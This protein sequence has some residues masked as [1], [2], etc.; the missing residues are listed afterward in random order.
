MMENIENFLMDLDAVV[1]E[2]NIKKVDITLQF[3]AENRVKPVGNLA[4]GRFTDEL[5]RCGCK[6]RTDGN[7]IWCSGITCDFLKEV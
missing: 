6:L 4:Y 1:H 3:G 2:H 5:C 7:L